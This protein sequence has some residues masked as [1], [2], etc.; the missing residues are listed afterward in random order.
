VTKPGAS[1]APENSAHFAV[2][3]TIDSITTSDLHEHTK[4]TIQGATND[5]RGFVAL[6]FLRSFCITR[7]LS[8]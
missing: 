1:A 8:F 4:S 7:Q 2:L 5:Y 3:R 6:A